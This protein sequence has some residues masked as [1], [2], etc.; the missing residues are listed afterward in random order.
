MYNKLR[1]EIKPSRY[2]FMVEPYIQQ[3]R[4][5]YNHV[6]NSVDDVI[7]DFQLNGWKFNGI[8]DGYYEFE[9]T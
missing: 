3:A 5:D 6:Y 1:L 9:R 4:F 7:L 2:G 8:I